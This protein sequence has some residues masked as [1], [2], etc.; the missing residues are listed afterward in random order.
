MRQSKELQKRLRA[1]IAAKQ[2]REDDI[3]MEH[4]NELAGAAVALFPDDPVMRELVVMPDRVLQ[5]YGTFLNASSMPLDM[6]SKRL[7][8][9]LTRLIDRLEYILGEPSDTEAPA[10]KAG[11]V[12]RSE[13]SEDIERILSALDEMRRKQP[14]L[15]PVE[16]LAFDFVTDTSLRQVLAADFVEAQRAF[17]VG[18]F[19]ASALL[20]GG[21]IEGMLL[22]TLRKPS[23]I[24]RP[25][26]QTAVANLQK[27]G[28]T[29][30]WDRVSLTQLLDAAYQLGLL[31]A[32][33]KRF[34]EG[35][36]D[37]RDTVHPNAELRIQSRA[38]KEE[39]QLL[40]TLVKLVYRQVTAVN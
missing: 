5:S 28:G 31:N 32:Q 39:A 33:T 34:V 2:F 7:D 16:V 30:N 9:R 24:A 27:V 20:T 1:N 19:K 18:A 35:A 10:M 13:R 4:Y 11:D 22:D 23:V 6:P 21:L 38:G 29:I 26:Y 40:L 8:A 3:Q 12:L 15:P 25:D 36:R 37:Y 14:E 17:A